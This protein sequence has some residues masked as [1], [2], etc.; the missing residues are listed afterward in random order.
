MTVFPIEEIYSFNSADDVT[1]RSRYEY[2]VSSKKSNFIRIITVYSLNKYSINCGA[3]DCLEEH[4][5][6]Y[7]VVTPNEQETCLCEACGKRF[8]A[9]NFDE[10]Q[11]KYIEQNRIR[12]Q[13]FR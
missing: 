10:Q 6:G 7:L 12:K 2:P 13:K 8:F 9:V 4:S 3:S 5:N 1:H 11:S